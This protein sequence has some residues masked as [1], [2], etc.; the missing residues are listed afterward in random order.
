[1][2]QTFDLNKMGVLPMTDGENAEI[3]GGIGENTV[4]GWVIKGLVFLYDHRSQ[5][6]PST[7]PGGFVGGI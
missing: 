5:L 2:T 1:M 7:K 3:S 6:T 4:I